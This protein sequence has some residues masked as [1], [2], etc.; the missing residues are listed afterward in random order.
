MRPSLIATLACLASSSLIAQTHRATA[1]H[2]AP[3]HAAPVEPTGPT[4]V[5]DTSSGRVVCRLYD[6]QAPQTVATFL[7]L[8]KGEKDWTGAD[9]TVR[10]GKPFYDATQLIGVTDGFRGGDR[11]AFSQGNAGPAVEPEKTGLDTERPGRLVAVVKDGKQNAASFVVLDHTIADFSKRGVVFGQCDDASVTV[12]ADIAH[13]LLSADNRPLHPVVLRRV[14]IVA[15]GQELPPPAPP[16]E[17]EADLTIPPL[18]APAVPAPDPTGPTA[19]IET[20][21]G[22]ISC[23]LFDK[24]APIGV[25]NFVALAN[26]T[27]SFK[28]P[29]TGVEV[30][31]RRFYDGLHFGRVIP[32][33]MIQNNDRPFDPKGDHDIGFHFGNEIVPGLSFDRPGRLAYAN[34]GPNTNNTEFFVTEHPI[35]RLDGSYTIF[36]QCDD[37]SVKVVEAAARIP[38]DD[39][40]KPLVPITIKRVTISK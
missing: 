13:T 12:A 26:G 20:T 17:G 14:A 2:A 22:T 30:K 1:S 3:A 40:D 28:N 37:A 6:K 33:F 36:G 27:K 9:G 32:D 4:A 35:R 10:H 18:P 24:E 31:G 15:A 23:K 19:I 38:R 5:F 7:A 39:H 25:A 29:S 21:L 34:S 11:E 16:M 8:A